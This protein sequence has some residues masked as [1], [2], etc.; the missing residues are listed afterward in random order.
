MLKISDFINESYEGDN[1]VVKVPGI[2]MTI[3]KK[4]ID[5][6][7][8]LLTPH[9]NKIL[10]NKRGEQ[11]GLPFEDIEPYLVTPTVDPNEKI[12]RFSNL[13]YNYHIRS[14]KCNPRRINKYKDYLTVGN[15]VC[16][17]FDSKNTTFRPYK[18][19]GNDLAPEPDYSV[20]EI[21]K[22]YDVEAYKINTL[23][24]GE[25]IYVNKKDLAVFL[26]IDASLQKYSYTLNKNK[27]NNKN[28]RNA[29]LGPAVDRLLKRFKISKEELIK[30]LQQ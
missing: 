26:I 28:K 13:D 18:D 5:E 24:Y 25:L 12:N 14:Y 2:S 23:T 30:Y 7:N 4:N 17:N 19:T 10:A 29:D 9:I 8:K 3:P 20:W 11:Y 1:F 16:V 22:G 15:A 21:E 27:N 6:V